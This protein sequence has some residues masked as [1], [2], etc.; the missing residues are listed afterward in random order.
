[1]ENRTITIVECP[2]D[3][4]QGIHN[5][6][7]TNI[8]VDYI[9]SLINVG[10]DI[11]DF[12]SFVS[13]RAVPQMRDTAN[14]IDGLNLQEN[15]SLLSV[16]LNKKGALSAISFDEIKILGFPLSISEIFQMK[17]S[18]QSIKSSLKL[19]DEI[20]NLCVKKNKKLLIYFSMAFGNP[21][22]EFC[23]YDLLF[24]YVKEIKNKGINMISIADTIGNSTQL[25]IKN[26]Y[27]QLAQDF[28]LLDIGLHLHSKK[29]DAYSKIESAWNAGCSRF[30]VA[31]SGFGGC[32]F[33]QSELI[34]NIET[35]CLLNFVAVNDINH[36]LNVL[37]FENACNSAKD[38]FNNYI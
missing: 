17:N 28:P 16:I 33:A 31:I 27:T 6:I 12:G 29:D 21:Y 24:H 18:N 13:P 4:M 9:N 1:M 14:V 38:I 5:F 23:D 37:A 2:R 30:D 19:I 36:N 10:F 26:I 34:G 3:A 32:P 15:T 11:I 25:S 7:P 35:Q 20:K 22:G 8:K